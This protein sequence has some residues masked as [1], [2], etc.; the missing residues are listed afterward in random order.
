MRMS[1]LGVDREDIPGAVV[2]VVEVEV[3]R[4]PDLVEYARG[5][6]SVVIGVGGYLPAPEGYRLHLVV[7]GVSHHSEATDLLD[8]VHRIVRERE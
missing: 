8:P 7:N 1:N 4:A 6:V 3:L 2:G 5:P